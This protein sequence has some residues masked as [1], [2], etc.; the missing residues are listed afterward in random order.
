[1]P[2]PDFYSVVCAVGEDGFAFQRWV[3]AEQDGLFGV[4][5]SYLEVVYLRNFQECGG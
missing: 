4:E 5:F 2:V 1:M 3:V